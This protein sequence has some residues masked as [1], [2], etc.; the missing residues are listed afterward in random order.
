MARLKELFEELELGGVETFLASGNVTFDAGKAEPA[1]LQ[2]R[3]E[4][5]LHKAL[6]YEVYTFLR[7]EQELVSLVKGCPFS[8][9]EV[10]A[11]AALNVI[12]LQA[13]LPPESEARLGKLNSG[14]DRLQ[15]TGREVW[16]LCAVKQSE[17][18]FS[19]AVFEKATGQRASFRG[20]NSLQRLAA[21][22]TSDC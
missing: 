19:N 16:W 5:H 7:S 10:K 3:I 15:A 1:S 2:R 17:S 8:E 12:L 9:A 22:F 18:T 21:K 13:P 4:A 11:A 20:F 14:P 6:G